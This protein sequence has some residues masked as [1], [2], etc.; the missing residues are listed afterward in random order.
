MFFV[1]HQAAIYF[2]PKCPIIFKAQIRTALVLLTTQ[3]YRTH[4]NAFYGFRSAI[5]SLAFTSLD[6]LWGT[7][8]NDVQF[9]GKGQLFWMQIFLCSFE[10][11]K[12]TQVMFWFLSKMDQ[13]KKVKAHY[14]PNYSEYLSFGIKIASIYFDLSH[15][16]G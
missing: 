10:P 5:F 8:I 3:G 4:S 12:R 11:K 9:Q 6:L 1:G 2:H 13:I 16:R 7:S 14:Y 15:F